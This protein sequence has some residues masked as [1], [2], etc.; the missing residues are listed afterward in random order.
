MMKQKQA[1]RRQ[2]VALATDCRVIRH[3]GLEST[4]NSR[5]ARFALRAFYRFRTANQECTPTRSHS[6][7]MS[8]FTPD[9]LDQL[10]KLREFCAQQD[11][12]IASLRK[13]NRELKQAMRRQAA[14]AKLPSEVAAELL[15]EIAQPQN[16]PLPDLAVIVAHPDDESVGAG[17]LLPRLKR[18][19]FLYATDGAPRNLQDAAAAG[20]RTRHDYALARHRERAAALAIAGIGHE[21]VEELGMVDQE[22]AL[23][24]TKLTREVAARLKAWQPA[25]VMTHPYEG[26]H[27]DHDAVAFAVHAACRLQEKCG[28]TPPAI[29]ET[30]SYHARHGRLHVCEFLANGGE[31]IVTLELNEAR[32]LFKKQLFTCYVSQRGTLSSFPL[33]RERYRQAPSYDFRRPPHDG[34]LFYER[35][36]WNFTGRQFRRLAAE[37]LQQLGVD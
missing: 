26:G 33:H 31:P 11:N 34:E 5:G 36:D 8:D 28:K 21:Q 18:A 29:L 3:F 2:F 9:L 27:P 17:G 19:H 12:E 1:K 4:R 7:C 6:D 10:T 22:A 13:E 23:D 35:C 16:D 14:S 15:T 30:T 25:A 37:A 32:R 20:Y 24:L